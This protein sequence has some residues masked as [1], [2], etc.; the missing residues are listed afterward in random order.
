MWSHELACINYLLQIYEELRS[1]FNQSIKIDQMIDRKRKSMW[2]SEKGL[3]NSAMFLLFFKTISIKRD[4]VQK[5]E[6][7]FFEDFWKYSFKISYLRKSFLNN[8]NSL[9]IFLNISQNLIEMWEFLVN[10]FSIFFY[11]TFY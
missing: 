2:W 5:N 10:V 11:K 4:W 1:S 9:A 8:S 7:I 6:G 3:V